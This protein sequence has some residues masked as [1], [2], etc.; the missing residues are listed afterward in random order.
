MEALSNLGNALCKLGRAERRREWQ[1]AIAVAPIAC[2][3]NLGALFAQQGRYQGIDVQAGISRPATPLRQPCGK[4]MR[5]AGP[6]R[7]PR[8]RLRV[9]E[10]AEARATFSVLKRFQLTADA[11]DIRGSRAPWRSHGSGPLCSPG[12]S[13]RS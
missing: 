1:R 9:V 10:T 7:L 6:A 13:P 5:I 4:S 12:R 8:L 11:P 3:A 2:W